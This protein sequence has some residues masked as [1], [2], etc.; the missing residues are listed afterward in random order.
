MVQRIG[1][2][3]GGLL[4][5]GQA[6]VQRLVD[7]PASRAPDARARWRIDAPIQRLVG[8]FRIDAGLADAAGKLLQVD[9]S[10]HTWLA[11]LLAVAV[12]WSARR[13]RP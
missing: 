10:V 4:D 5:G 11:E 12:I 8:F 13:D 3:L 6:R 9:V 1:V 7:A 2:E